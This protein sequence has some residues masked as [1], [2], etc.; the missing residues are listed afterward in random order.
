MTKMHYC[1]VHFEHKSS[2]VLEKDTGTALA[3]LEEH[4]S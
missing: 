3:Q 2:D 4:W 1:T